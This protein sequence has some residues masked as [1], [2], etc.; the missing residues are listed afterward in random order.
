MDRAEY[1]KIHNRANKWLRT[2][3]LMFW[4]YV[5]I[6]LA[7]FFWTG[8]QPEHGWQTGIVNVILGSQLLFCFILFLGVYRIDLSEKLKC[9][10]CGAT[11]YRKD[12]IGP[13]TYM[14]DKCW[15]VRFDLI[16]PA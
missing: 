6:C 12:L 11:C 15:N 16:R 14:C 9:K 13:N 5:L 10:K 8:I 4:P 7:F 3:Q 1:L 2:L